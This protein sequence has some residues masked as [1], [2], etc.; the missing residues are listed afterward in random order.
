MIRFMQVPAVDVVLLNRP[1]IPSSGGAEPSVVV[2][3]ASI[4]NA[5]YDA[6]GVRIRQVPFTPQR[7][8]AALKSKVPPRA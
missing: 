8:L 6:I 5:V 1:E 3:P 4:A 7:V 2:I